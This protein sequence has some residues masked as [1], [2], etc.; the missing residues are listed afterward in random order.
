MGDIGAVA[1]LLNTIA[2]WITD[3]EEYAK[4]SLDRQLTSLR[5][6]VVRALYEKDDASVDML[7]AELRRLSDTQI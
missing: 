2:K 6:G 1:T 5:E 7:L 3:P 4:W